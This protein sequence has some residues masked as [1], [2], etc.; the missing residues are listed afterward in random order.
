MTVESLRARRSDV[1]RDIRERIK[2]RPGLEAERWRAE[3]ADDEN[4]DAIEARKEELRELDERIGRLESARPAD[5][6]VAGAPRAG[7]PCE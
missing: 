2:R 6:G 3:R 7:L 1:E 5:R 4:D